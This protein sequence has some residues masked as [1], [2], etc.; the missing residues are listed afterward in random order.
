[1]F[2]T[3]DEVIAVKWRWTVEQGEIVVSDGGV[4]LVSRGWN[5]LA[6]EIDL[7]SK[8]A[9]VLGTGGGGNEQHV[10]LSASEWTLYRDESTDLA[11]VIS[12]TLPKTRLA[13]KYSGWVT[14][15]QCSR[16]TLYVVFYR[17]SLW[18]RLDLAWKVRRVWH[19]VAPPR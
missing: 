2:E 17:R 5:F 1:M 4:Q 7:V 3:R 9:E 18:S 15:A 10:L 13:A 12:F 11:T 19:R 8:Y 14:L 16:Y 6:Y